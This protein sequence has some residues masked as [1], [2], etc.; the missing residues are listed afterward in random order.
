MGCAKQFTTYLVLQIGG[1][2]ICKNKECGVFA[3][4][5]RKNTLLNKKKFNKNNEINIKDYIH[6]SQQKM[7]VF[8]YMK[9]E[10]LK[11]G[12]L[13]RN[14]FSANFDIQMGV[15]WIR[16]ISEKHPPIASLIRRNT[17]FRFKLK[18]RGCF[19]TNGSLFESQ[20]TPV[21]FNFQD[22]NIATFIQKIRF[23]LLLCKMGCFILFFTKKSF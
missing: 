6:Y 13:R 20:N 23:T 16:L 11:Y 17:Y 2:F 21:F 10:T 3:D 18:K 15:F 4:K 14:M 19:P 12:I 5:Q 1:V 22:V 7:S 8:V 9:I